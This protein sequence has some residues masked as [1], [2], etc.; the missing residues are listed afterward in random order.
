M[1]GGSIKSTLAKSKDV[2]SLAESSKEGYGSKG[3]VFPVVIL[4]MMMLYR[5]KDIKMNLREIGCEIPYCGLGWGPVSG[6]GFE[7]T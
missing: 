6:G 3:A 4:M 7:K 2:T 5:W 1:C